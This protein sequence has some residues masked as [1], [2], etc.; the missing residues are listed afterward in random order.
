MKAR[1]KR[2]RFTI[3]HITVETLD[4]PVG[5]RTFAFYAGPIEPVKP[6]ALFTGHI[7]KGMGTSLLLLAKHIKELEGKSD[8]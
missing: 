2:R 4:C 7:T 1:Q 8:D 3:A 6:R 5:G